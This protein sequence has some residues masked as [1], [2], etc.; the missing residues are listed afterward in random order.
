MITETLKAGTL[1][2][3]HAKRGEE[4]KAEIEGNHLVVWLTEPPEN[5]RANRELVTKLSKMLDARVLILRGTR[6][7]RKLLKI[8]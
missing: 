3:A 5:G 8:G 1:I 6:S 7:R 4:F 2:Q